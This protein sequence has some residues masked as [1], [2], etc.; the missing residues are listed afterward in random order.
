VQLSKEQKLAR[1]KTRSKPKIN[2]SSRNS[3]LALTEM[4]FGSRTRTNDGSNKLKDLDNDVQFKVRARYDSRAITGFG[5]VPY[6][7]YMKSIIGRKIM[8]SWL[9]ARI[10]QVERLNNK[11]IL[12]MTKIEDY[13]AGSK[14]GR[15][16]LKGLQGLGAIGD[17][18]D[19]LQIVMT[20]TDA[21][22]YCNPNE[23]TCL[24]PP[25]ENLLNSATLSNIKRKGIEAQ[26][27]KLTQHNNEIDNINNE[28][29]DDYWPRVH[30]KFPFIS[31]PLDI[32]DADAGKGDPYWIEVRVQTEVDAIRE[33]Y[34]KDDSRRYKALLRSDNYLGAELYDSIIQDGTDSILYYLEGDEGVFSNTELDDLYREAYTTVCTY[35]GGIV[36][37]DV[38]PTQT[39]GS[40]TVMTGR[41]RFQ[42]G[43]KNATDCHARAS[44][45]INSTDTNEWTA[46]VYAEWFSFD[47]TDLVLSDGNK[48]IP[49]NDPIRTNGGAKTGACMATSSGV[50]SMCSIYNSQYNYVT[51][52]C[53][54]TPEYCRSIGTCYKNSDKTCYLPHDEMKAYSF[55]FGTGGPRAWIKAYGCED[56]AAGL[57]IG[58][59]PVSG[60]V[61]SQG[62]SMLNDAI[63]N[64]RNWGP[65]LKSSLS[66]PT[67]AIGFA[68]SVIG[69]GGAALLAAGAAS[70][71]F[72]VAVALA[73]GIAA[74]ISA[75]VEAA[76]SALANS[77]ASTGDAREYHIG[78]LKNENGE[79]GIYAVTLG[80]GWVTKPLQ[81][82]KDGTAMSASAI[83]GL[84]RKDFFPCLSESPKHDRTSVEAALRFDV[85]SCGVNQAKRQQL[86]WED[87]SMIRVAS[88]SGANYVW[89]MPRKPN[90]TVFVNTDIGELITETTYLWNRIWTNGSDPYYPET[91]EGNMPFG[92]DR[93]NAWYYQ[94]AY[95][96]TKM[97]FPTTTTVAGTIPGDSTTTSNT[98]IISVTSTTEFMVGH[99]LD[100]NSSTA[101][102]IT[103]TATIIALTPSTMT[104][105]YTNQ[106]TTT[107]STV[108]TIK[109]TTPSALWNTSLLERYFTRSTITTMRQYYC[110][111]MFASDAT[112][113]NLDRRCFAFI[114]IVTNYGTKKFMM[115]PMT[116][117]SARAT[118]IN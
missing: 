112:G 105:S 65:G 32:L 26:I 98:K 22:Y 62:R 41:P 4:L 54:Y 66:N 101:I 61:T 15:I 33:K 55:F 63:S 36:Y 5:M 116:S 96:R 71:P 45:W 106:K 30:D 13:L 87:S 24:F 8:T 12:G 75:G 18:L 19:V 118:I 115:L 3:S 7:K 9:G 57:V 20:F 73:V 78:G 79:I 6:Y 100:Q 77:L 42:C 110:N 70:G 2:K 85:N 59:S 38:H 23:S 82:F 47:D 108:K 44:S 92:I 17:I 37:E 49:A 111:Q 84:V 83:P 10:N 67:N 86:C 102:G 88:D 95:D 107:V 94:L 11:V 14:A 64:Q 81:I 60:L 93:G 68:S 46:G 91:P 74:G 31:G 56:M 21:F 76:N 89:C 27:L 16:T 40:S 51:H 90:D 25:E 53:E 35:N 43:W 28:V 72:F 97:K 104:L 114:N 29:Y 109:S 58:L 39:A 80:D 1:K 103:G 34:C 99:V 69:V 52:T 50:H 48:I 117:L 113:V